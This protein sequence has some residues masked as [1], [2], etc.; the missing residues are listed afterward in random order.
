M[1]PTIAVRVP[2]AP[3]GAPVGPSKHRYSKSVTDTLWQQES[4]YTP[5]K[6]PGLMT[7]IQDGS[8]ASKQSVKTVAI[9]P[10]GF[11]EIKE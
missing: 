11:P 6:G 10:R 9:S 7:K 3:S 4:G 8:A 2:R 1:T 5:T